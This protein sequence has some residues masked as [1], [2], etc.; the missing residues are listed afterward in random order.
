LASPITRCKTKDN[1]APFEPLADVSDSYSS[2]EGA[3]Y[4]FAVPEVSDVEDDSSDN[5][6]DIEE[7]G[8]ISVLPPKTTT[9]NVRGNSD[10][11]VDLT[12]RDV[13]VVDIVDMTGAGVIDLS[14]PPPALDLEIGDDDIELDTTMLGKDIIDAPSDDEAT[15]IDLEAEENGTDVS[16]SDSASSSND[17]SGHSENRLVDSMEDLEGDYI[18]DDDLLSDGW[19]SHWISHEVTLLTPVPNLSDAPDWEDASSLEDPVVPAAKNVT[20]ESV[21]GDEDVELEVYDMAAEADYNATSY[22]STTARMAVPSILNPP[23][24]SETED[25]AIPQTTMPPPPLPLAPLL[26]TGEEFLNTPQTFYS[27]PI[28]S[29]R[30]DVFNE[31][32]SAVDFHKRTGGMRSSQAGE[33]S[34]R[35]TH[36]GIA[37][38]VDSSPQQSQKS[39]SA[40]PSRKRKADDI[41]KLS[42]A[43]ATWQVGPLPPDPVVIPLEMDA[44]PEQASVP[45]PP[46]DEPL[47]ISTSSVRPAK[48]MRLRNIAERIGYAAL[49]GATVGAAIF[50]TLIYTAPSFG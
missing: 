43:E 2:D 16:F 33:P 39:S 29:D 41:S 7:T 48:K 20:V 49:G 47:A 13:A 44:K 40:V 22:P 1:R 28:S 45:A 30:E 26:V 12:V 32:I 15:S 18:S 10:N 9:P 42:A 21:V 24:S 4:T 8:A 38:I 6:S 34:Q 50:T 11:F 36:V 27:W 19:F 25:A 3:G 14:S 31:S 35:R 17:E 46:S 23:A 5:D 37:D